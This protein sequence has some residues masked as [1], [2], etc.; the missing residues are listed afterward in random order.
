M[1]IH[2]DVS[3][4]M[5]NCDFDFFIQKFMVSE[6]VTMSYNELP[7][8]TIQYFCYEMGKIGTHLHI[9]LVLF[10]STIFFTFFHCMKKNEKRKNAK[11]MFNE[12]W[13]G[14][15]NIDYELKL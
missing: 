8:I 7:N 11:I 6:R 1:K 13:P 10:R 4:N 15:T 2:Y 3:H 12:H 9:E 14:M 5:K